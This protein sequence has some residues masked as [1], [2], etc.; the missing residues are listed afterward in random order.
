MIGQIVVRVLNQSVMI[1]T[2]VHT[3]L[4]VS[5]HTVMA[6]L[7]LLLLLFII[8]TASSSSCTVDGVTH[9][10]GTSFTAPDGCN[11]W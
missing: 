8:I 7:L 9:A 3:V 6:A 10:N 4:R 2:A 1:D 5:E 11:T